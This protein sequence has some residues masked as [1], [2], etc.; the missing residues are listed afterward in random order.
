MPCHVDLNINA[1]AAINVLVV[2]NVNV[3]LS[4][5]ALITTNITAKMNIKTAIIIIIITTII[6]GKIMN[7][8]KLKLDVMSCALAFAN[9]SAIVWSFVAILIAFNHIF[10]CIR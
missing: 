1:I 10:T 9:A 5:N 2:K 4:V 6:K 3:V 7:G 8:Q